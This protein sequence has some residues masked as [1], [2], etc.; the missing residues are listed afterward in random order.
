M[1]RRIQPAPAR[2]QEII[3]QRRRAV[4]VPPTPVSR[5]QGAYYGM[6]AAIM[7]EQCG[8]FHVAGTPG[9][10]I[11]VGV[12]TLPDLTADPVF[13]ATLPYQ[14]ATTPPASGT[15]TYNVLVRAMSQYGL[16]SQNQY[17]YS[18]TIDSIGDLVLPAIASP[19]PFAAYIAPGTKIRLLAGYPGYGI[20]QYPATHWR[21]WIKSAV[22]DV[23]VDTPTA[24]SLIT[25]PIMTPYLSV[26]LAAGTWHVALCLYR[27]TDARLSGPARATLVIAD[28]LDAPFGSP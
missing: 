2:R 19:N 28:P 5:E 20:D 25:S 14:I 8:G 24:S 3:P 22:P 17:A 11:Y 13:T 7:R 12:D 15:K 1:V 27:S 23:D 10:N 9:Y 21:V 6:Q 26:P 16:E 18:F 4:Y